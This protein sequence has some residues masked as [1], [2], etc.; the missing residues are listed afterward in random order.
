MCEWNPDHLNPGWCL[1]SLG[2][3][4]HGKSVLQKPPLV[5]VILDLAVAD[6]VVREARRSAWPGT[7][8]VP[9]T[10]R[11]AELPGRGV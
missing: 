7:L 10:V 11:S 3:L 2:C 6:F 8:S 1:D 4:E 9:S 5:H